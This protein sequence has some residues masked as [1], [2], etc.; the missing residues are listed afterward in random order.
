MGCDG[1]TY[2][3]LKASFENKRKE[4]LLKFQENLAEDNISQLRRF[5]RSS[6]C[7]NQTTSEWK[8]KE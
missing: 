4:E 8:A 3:T 1:G 2:W 5:K 7:E 6:S